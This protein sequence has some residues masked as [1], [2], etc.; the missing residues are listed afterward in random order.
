MNSTRTIDKIPPA[1]SRMKRVFGC[2]YAVLL[3][4]RIQHAAFLQQN[5][6]RLKCRVMS[7]DDGDRLEGWIFAL[8]PR[9]ALSS[10]NVPARMMK[11]RKKPK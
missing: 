3:Y 2:R 10:R 7:P 5:G 1:S 8:D 6:W 11:G 4:P 9:E